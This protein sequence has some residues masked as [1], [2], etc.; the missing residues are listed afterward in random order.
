[1]LIQIFKCEI[2]E[3]LLQLNQFTLRKRWS[4]QIFLIST[5]LY[6]KSLT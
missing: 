6:P 3:L 4:L 1:M 2:R 5:K